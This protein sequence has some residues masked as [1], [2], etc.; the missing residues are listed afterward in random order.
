[1]TEKLEKL[2]DDVIVEFNDN[3]E[4]FEGAVVRFLWLISKILIKIWI[5]S[6][7]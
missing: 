2:A 1:M 6:D 4:T 7:K 5:S 3:K